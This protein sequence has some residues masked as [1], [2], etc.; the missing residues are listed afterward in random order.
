MTR[1]A[2]FALEDATWITY[3]SVY[4]EDISPSLTSMISH[5]PKYKMKDMALSHIALVIKSRV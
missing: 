4:G 5:R 1:E 3:A 2:R